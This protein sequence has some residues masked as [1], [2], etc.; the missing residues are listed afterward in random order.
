MAIVQGGE[1]PAP[2]G[3]TGFVEHS[4]NT[5]A[6]WFNLDYAEQ[7]RWKRQEQSAQLAF[8]RESAFN[9]SEAQ[10]NR[11]WQ[12]RLANTSYQRVVEDLKKA[13][14]NPVLAYGQGGAS[15][16]TG[17][18]ASA[19]GSRS[20]Y[21]ANSQ[22]GLGQFLTSIAQI[23]AG[24]YT[25]GASNATKLAS[26][27]IYANSRNRESTLQYMYDKNGRVSTRYKFYD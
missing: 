25:A 2:V 6:N 18:Q 27:N 19:G 5:L 7:L 12:E 22:T 4:G 11:D 14:L 17:S 9:A 20:G 21:N 24:L 26:A 3:G 8:A 23:V 10:K 16:P 1:I 13:G 15:T